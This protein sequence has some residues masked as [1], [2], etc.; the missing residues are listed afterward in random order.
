MWLLFHYILEADCW[1]VK[2]SFHHMAMISPIKQTNNK[3]NL[4]FLEAFLIS[5]FMALFTIK[6]LLIRK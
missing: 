1:N 4:Q 6:Y 5:K 2:Q 3:N